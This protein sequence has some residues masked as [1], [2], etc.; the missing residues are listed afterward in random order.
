VLR[1]NVV[2]TRGCYKF[3]QAKASK[4]DTY[5][6]VFGTLLSELLFSLGHLAVALTLADN[7]SVYVYFTSSLATVFLLAL[8]RVLEVW[9]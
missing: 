7:P 6:D 8:L 9:T 4:I 5:N 2:F 1:G 3:S